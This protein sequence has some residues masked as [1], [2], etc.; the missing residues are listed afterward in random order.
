MISISIISS[1]HVWNLLKREVFMSSWRHKSIL[2]HKMIH[3]FA[4]GW[5][6]TTILKLIDKI[7]IAKY[8]QN[9]S[10]ITL[11]GY[12][13]ICYKRPH[14]FNFPQAKDISHLHIAAR[15][16]ITYPCVPQLLFRPV[17][18]F[19]WLP[20]IF[21]RYKNSTELFSIL[22]NAHKN[23]KFKMAAQKQ[24]ILITRHVRIHDSHN[25]STGTVPPFKINTF[26]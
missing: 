12:K 4:H 14:A 13:I 7:K 6:S 16:I 21:F 24:E 2:R 10:I 15:M 17:K 11:C 1:K 20:P 9:N 25:F 22:C 26:L 18:K 5:L 3:I 23:R 19:Q 8:W